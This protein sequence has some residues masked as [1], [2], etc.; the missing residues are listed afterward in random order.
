MKKTFK[1][2]N[3]ECAN[4]AAKIERKT[5]ALE[6]VSSASV[7]FVTGRLVMEYEAAKE[8]QIMEQLAAIVRRTDPGIVMKEV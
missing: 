5:S 1:L 3:L 7:T 2:E 8:P 6:G 4:C